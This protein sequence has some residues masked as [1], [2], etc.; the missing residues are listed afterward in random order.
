MEEAHEIQ[1]RCGA[2][3]ALMSKVSKKNLF[4][5]LRTFKIL[6]SREFQNF[7]LRDFNNI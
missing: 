4:I 2:Q 7:I 3:N 6:C 1:K 5:C